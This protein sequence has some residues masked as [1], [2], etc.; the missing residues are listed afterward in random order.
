MNEN[1][2]RVFLAADVVNESVAS[3]SLEQVNDLGRVPC[4]NPARLTPF[5]RKPFSHLGLRNDK[6]G[7]LIPLYRQS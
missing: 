4:P 1:K 3:D 7:R 6:P 5:L 2:W